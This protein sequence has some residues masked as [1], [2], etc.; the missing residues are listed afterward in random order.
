MV[1]FTTPHPPSTSTRPPRPASHDLGH[2]QIFRDKF[3]L[4]IQHC[5]VSSSEME[6]AGGARL[7]VTLCVSYGFIHHLAIPDTISETWLLIP[8]KTG[9]KKGL[10]TN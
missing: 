6:S 7:L 2:W 8:G 1:L 10:E 5:L 9:G 3:E 4:Q